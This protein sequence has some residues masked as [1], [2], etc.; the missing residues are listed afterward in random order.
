MD[1]LDCDW[2]RVSDII[3]EKTLRYLDWEISGIEIGF[4]TIPSEINLLIGKD[5]LKLLIT[6]SANRSDF[7][8]HL[9]FI[10]SNVQC[11]ARKVKNKWSSDLSKE[12]QKAYDKKDIK[13]FYGLLGQ[14]NGPKF[15]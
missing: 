10:K 3:Y 7:A 1:F 5:H 8:A 12:I 2:E 4:P 15:T 13:A 14:E 6:S 9:S 11:C